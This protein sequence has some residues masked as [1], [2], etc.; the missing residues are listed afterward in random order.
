MHQILAD[1]L[2]LS[3]Q[4]FSMNTWETV[5]NNILNPEKEIIIDVPLASKIMLSG[6]TWPSQAWSELAD[7]ELLASNNDI[8][9][10][11]R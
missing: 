6:F 5:L 9:C 4:N 3:L 8:T 10:S 7:G 2:Q 1:A 11:P